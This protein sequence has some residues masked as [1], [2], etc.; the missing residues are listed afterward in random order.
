MGA[1]Q[2]RPAP[3]PPSHP[4]LDHAS[5]AQVS[6]KIVIGGSSTWQ[7]KGWV[8]QAARCGGT[9]WAEAA[10]EAATGGSRS[11]GSARVGSGRP[12]HGQARRAA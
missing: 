9:R 6:H 11:L 5:P 10:A 12:R 2:G 8:E 4:P 3:P 7:R 1:A